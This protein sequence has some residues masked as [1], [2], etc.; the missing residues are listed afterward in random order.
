MN[1]MKERIDESKQ[2]VE[3]KQSYDL[4]IDNYI[5]LKK[6]E[7]QLKDDLLKIINADSSDLDEMTHYLSRI[8]STDKVSTIQTYSDH[9]NRIVRKYCFIIDGAIISGYTHVEEIVN[10]IQDIVQNRLQNKLF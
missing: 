8:Q 2:I 5:R 4:G 6:E 1:K 7:M 10:N 9:I 3:Q